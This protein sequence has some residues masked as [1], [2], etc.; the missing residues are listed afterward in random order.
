MT[1]FHNFFRIFVA[2]LHSSQTDTAVFQISHL[3]AFPFR[4]MSA[5]FRKFAARVASCA[6]VLP[7]NPSKFVVMSRHFLKLSFYLCPTRANLCVASE[8]ML[9]GQVERAADLLVQTLAP[10]HFPFSEFF[11]AWQSRSFRS[12]SSTACARKKNI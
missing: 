11:S 3:V 6:L 2:F 12:A 1:S 5:N 4:P 7:G 10:S 8:S 9:P